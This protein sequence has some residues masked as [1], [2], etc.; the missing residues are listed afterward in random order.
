M[1]YQ[2]LIAELALCEARLTDALARPEVR[3]REVLDLAAQRNNLKDMIIN[4]LLTERSQKE[5]A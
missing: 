1:S 2:E 5:A 3:M 4:V